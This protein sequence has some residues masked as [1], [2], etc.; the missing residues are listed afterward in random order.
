MKKMKTLASLVLALVLAFALTVPAF[1]ANSTA[2]SIIISNASKGVTYYALK[3]FDAEVTDAAENAGIA[4]YYGDIKDANNITDT[5][6]K[7]MFVGDNAVFDMNSIGQITKKDGV[8]DATV[9]AAVAAWAKKQ[10]LSDSVPHGTG[11][12]GALTINLGADNYGYYAVISDQSNAAVTVNSTN[13]T[14]TISDKTTVDVPTIPTDAKTIVGTDVTYQ[15]GDTV[16]YRLEVPTTNWV[17]TTTDGT[18]TE[19]KVYNY[20][21]T[22]TSSASYLKIDT[23]SVVVK[24]KNYNTDD[25]TAVPLTKVATVRR[26]SNGVMTISIPWTDTSN[27]IG[28]SLYENRT[29]I[30]VTYSATVIG[31]GKGTNTLTASYNGKA[32]TGSSTKEIYNV[33]V[34]VD[35]HDE[36]TPSTKLAGATF[37]LKNAAGKYYKY[38]AASGENP[39]TVTWVDNLVDTTNSSNNA[40]TYTTNSSGDLENNFVGLEPGTYTLVETAAPDGYNKM[41]DKEIIVDGSETDSYTYE[42]DVPNRVG[43]TLP[44][45]GG[46]GTTLFYTIGGLLV[47]CSAI[48]IVTKKRMSSMA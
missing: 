6:I 45:T 12:G 4:Y 48:L 22:D 30:V 39:A 16:S 28:N 35:K 19:E 38:N 37:A 42:V 26:D 43:T 7:A 10:T 1:A 13:P 32:I 2:P 5:D 9:T 31:T 47:V 33:A 24:V 3:L 36:Q 40:T 11:A 29:V 27:S 20:T 23:N 34:S 17:R 44:D 41:A 46:M 15:L 8:N 25:S 21:L 14:V 18:T